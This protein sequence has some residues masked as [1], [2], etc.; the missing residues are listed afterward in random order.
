ME[1]RSVFKGSEILTPA[2]PWT[3]SDNVMLS[4]KPDT[5]HKYGVIPLM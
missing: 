5:K 4:E 2:L 3:S 1:D